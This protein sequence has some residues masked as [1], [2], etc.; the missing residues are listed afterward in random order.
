M[1]TMGIR[2]STNQIVSGDR[3]F[4]KV[5]VA[6]DYID[7]KYRRTDVVEV[8]LPEYLPTVPQ[9]DQYT[10]VI[11]EEGFFKNQNW[12]VKNEV[13][14]STHYLKLPIMNGT[15]APVRMRKGSE[16]MLCYPTGKIDDGFL[17]FIRHKDDVELEEKGGTTDGA[18][19]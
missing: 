8:N 5:Y 19:D 18:S 9:D 14:R 17:I 12:P 11:A 7:D 4:M 10:E 6:R 15:Y 13:I 3:C 2:N 16:F 1:F